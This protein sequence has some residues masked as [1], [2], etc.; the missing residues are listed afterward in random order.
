M[1]IIKIVKIKCFYPPRILEETDASILVYIHATVTEI[2]GF[3]MNAE[4][5]QQQLIFLALLPWRKQFTNSISYKYTQIVR[6]E[7][8]K[9]QGDSIK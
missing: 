9:K 5:K 6:G 3:N 8:R 7:I 4:N 2:T 1:W